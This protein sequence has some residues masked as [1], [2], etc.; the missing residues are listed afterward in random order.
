MLVNIVFNTHNQLTR[1]WRGSL[2]EVDLIQTLVRACGNQWFHVIAVWIFAPVAES[3]NIYHREIIKAVELDFIFFSSRKKLLSLATE[4]VLE[5]LSWLRNISRASNLTQQLLGPLLAMNVSSALLYVIMFTFYAIEDVDSLIPFLWD[6]T[7]IADASVR[8]WV[9]AHAADSLRSMV[10][11]VNV[12]ISKAFDN[13]L[14]TE[15]KSCP[16]ASADP[17]KV[18]ETDASETGSTR[19]DRKRDDE[20]LE[21]S[22]VTLLITEIAKQRHSNELL[23]GAL[24]VGKKTI[25]MVTRALVSETVESINPFHCSQTLQTIATYLIIICQFKVTVEINTR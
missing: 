24:P 18:H 2:R 16:G 10:R 13:T 22:Q 6:V 1:S 20:S 19:N 15:L 3:I 23:M 4:S 11:N 25:L 5:K 12:C 7:D 17:R 9:I 21:I 14:I 8:Y